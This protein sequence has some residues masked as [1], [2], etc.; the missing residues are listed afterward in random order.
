[1]ISI[2]SLP[3]LLRDSLN[4]SGI[5]RLENL[6]LIDHAEH[7]P[8]VLGINHGQS[9][10]TAFIKGPER[11]FEAVCRHERP[12]RAGRTNRDAFTGT[13]WSNQGGNRQSTANSARQ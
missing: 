8:A 4:E 10:E 1:M 12:L 9:F 3:L 11:G 2:S 13:R 7:L 6:G 5:E